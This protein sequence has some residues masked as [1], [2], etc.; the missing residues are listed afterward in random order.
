MNNEKIKYTT[1]FDNKS[2]NKIDLN[3]KKKSYSNINKND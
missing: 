1:W 3:S 2:T